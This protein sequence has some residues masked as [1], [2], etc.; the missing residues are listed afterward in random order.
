MLILV[1]FITFFF[2]W[3]GE[4]LGA[5]CWFFCIFFFFYFSNEAGFFCT[6]A[7]VIKQLCPLSVLSMYKLHCINTKLRA[8]EV[9]EKLE[10]NKL[11]RSQM[12]YARQKLSMTGRCLDMWK[13]NQFV[14]CR[15]WQADHHINAWD[16]AAKRNFCHYMKIKS[17]MRIHSGVCAFYELH[18]TTNFT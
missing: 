4:R 3:F 11:L 18:Y 9:P 6:T 15:K 1:Y 5:F 13:L 17:L 8:E 16:S 2:S 14:Y 7:S 10:A 12:A